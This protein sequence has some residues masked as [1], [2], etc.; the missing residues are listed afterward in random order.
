LATIRAAIEYGSLLAGATGVV[1]P[2]AAAMLVSLVVGVAL[3]AIAA[4]GPAWL[5]A[6]LSPMEAMRV[7]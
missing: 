6:R 7:E 4:V 5:A 2:V 3:A 1:L